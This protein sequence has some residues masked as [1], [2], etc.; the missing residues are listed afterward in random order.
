WACMCNPEITMK[1]KIMKADA[2]FI[3]TILAERIVIADSATL[4][5]KYVIRYDI[6]IEKIYKGE[7]TRDTVIFIV[8]LSSC[9]YSFEVN[10]KYII[11]AWENTDS[12][13]NSVLLKSEINTSYSTDKCSGTREYNE[14]QALEIEAYLKSKEYRKLIRKTNKG[15]R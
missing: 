1:E 2:V 6:L 14:R 7:F 15:L 11:Y 10:N 5:P 12:S 13:S 3:G 4:E 9:Q 8:K